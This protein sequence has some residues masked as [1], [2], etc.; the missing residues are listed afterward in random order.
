MPSK[1]W[2]GYWGKKLE[3]DVTKENHMKTLG[4]KHILTGIKDAMEGGIAGSFQLKKASAQLMIM[5]RHS[6]RW[7]HEG[8]GKYE[9]RDQK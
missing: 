5:S 1:T 8:T 3:P 6:P 7:H 4:M 2:G 9:R